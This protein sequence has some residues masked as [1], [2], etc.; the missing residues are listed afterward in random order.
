[1][2]QYVKEKYHEKIDAVYH[3][4]NKGGGKLYYI[5]C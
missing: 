5:N 4:S 1:M 2:N 3:K